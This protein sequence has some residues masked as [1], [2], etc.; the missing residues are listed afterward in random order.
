VIFRVQL[1]LRAPEHVLELGVVSHPVSAENAV[2]S[3][4]LRILVEE[5]A[6]PVASENTDVIVG[7]RGV[8]PA[9]GWPLA[10]GPVRPVGV[11]V[12]D[13]FAE[14]VVEMSSAGDEDAVGA[15]APGAGDPPLAD[16]VRPR[17]LDR[18]LDDPHADRGEDGVE[19]AGVLDVRTFRACCTVQAAVGG[20]VMPARWTRRL[21]CSMTNR[22]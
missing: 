3:R 7:D 9:I 2:T 17:R 19:R 1:F 13:V 16:R 5:A 12:I 10:E 6:E 15:L 4:D 8:G 21:W 18:G 11:V 20:A 14:D 22:T